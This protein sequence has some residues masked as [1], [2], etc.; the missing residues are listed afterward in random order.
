VKALPAQPPP[1]PTW[2]RGA[3][4]ALRSDCTG[5]ATYPEAL[6]ASR[7]WEFKEAPIPSTAGLRSSD[8]GAVS[9]LGTKDGTGLPFVDACNARPD[10]HGLDQL[11]MR[12]MLM[13][14]AS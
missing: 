6:K 7:I 14:V 13:C 1:W 2:P 5:I 12:A 3:C 11:R 9:R 8:R 4:A 10:R